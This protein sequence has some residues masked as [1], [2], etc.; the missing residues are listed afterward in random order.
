VKK[1]GRNKRQERN[2]KEVKKNEVTRVIGGNFKEK[3][4]R[5]KEKRRKG[6]KEGSK[7]K[8]RK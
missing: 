5:E 6:E 3:G 4:E 2:E 8:R 7:N 1:K